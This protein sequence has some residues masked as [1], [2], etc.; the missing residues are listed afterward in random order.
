VLKDNFRAKPRTQNRTSTKLDLYKKE[1]KQEHERE[2]S[3]KGRT[4]LKKTAR[5][6]IM[7]KIACIKIMIKASK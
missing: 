3:K 1:Q 2:L 5:S 4:D 7:L 6:K